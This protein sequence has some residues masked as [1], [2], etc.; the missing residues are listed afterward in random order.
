M[1]GVWDLAGSPYW[2]EGDLAVTAGQTLT[3]EPAVEVRFRGPYAM[4][5]AG[6][7]LAVGTEADSILFTRDQ[8][9]AAHRWHGIDMVGAGAST[10]IAYARVEYVRAPDA[11]PD[12]RGGAMYVEECSPHI[13]HC[14]LQN[15]ESHN[16]NQNGMGGGVACISSSAVI[17]FCVI[18]HN[19]ADSGG[20][21]CTLEYGTEI[22]RNNRIEGN[23]AP[24]CGGGI[25]AGVRS[26]P[27]IENNVIAGNSAQGWGGGGITLWNWYAVFGQS[28]TVR[29]N[30]IAGNTTGVVGGGFYIRYDTSILENNTVIGNHATGGGGGVYVLNAGYGDYPP[31]LRNFVIWGNTGPDPSIR[32]ESST[33]SAAF[34]VYSDV[35]GGFAGTGNLDEDPLLADEMGHLGP[36]SPCIDA[37]D[38]SPA[39]EDE[40][41]PPS[42]GGARNDMG[43]LLYTSPSPRDSA[44][45]LVWRL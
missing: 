6:T 23:T 21:I 42:L 4:R 34:V 26:S 12:V 39:F 9:I 27:V 25:Y 36:G 33:G 41:F 13:H 7:L 5:V 31:E 20:G 37:G 30:V 29:N 19:T 1:S 45:Y 24:Y 44:V 22:I 2:V 40:C 18:R 15:N 35:E 8:P 11:Y 32:L 43:C 17:E 16:A 38:P 28:K 3:I 10:E 14:L